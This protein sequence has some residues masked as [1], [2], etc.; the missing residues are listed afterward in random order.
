MFEDLYHIIIIRGWK[1]SYLFVLNLK[2]IIPS[3]IVFIYKSYY[4]Q[5]KNYVIFDVII[6]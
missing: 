6:I 2:H 3:K 1:C 4:I 5:K